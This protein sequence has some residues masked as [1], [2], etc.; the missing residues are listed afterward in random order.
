MN[1]NITKEGIQK[2]LEWMK[3]V[4]IGGFQNF[5]ASLLTPVVVPKKLVFMT[6]DWKNAFKFTADLASKL[7]LEMAIARFAGLERNG[8]PVGAPRRWDEEIRL[9]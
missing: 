7:N 3:R 1:G 4:G 5:D 2:D 6:P 9:D 8:W